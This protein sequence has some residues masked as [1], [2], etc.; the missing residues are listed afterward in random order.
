MSGSVFSGNYEKGTGIAAGL[1]YKKSSKRK[2]SV[3]MSGLYISSNVT[4]LGSQINLQRNMGQLTEII[5]RLSTG[6]KINSGKDDPSGLIA[7]ELLKSDITA[8]KQAI[9]NTTKA[10]SVVAIADSA[11]GQISSLL[12]DIRGLVNASA[13]TGGMTADQIAANQ[14]QVDASID[15]IDRIAKTTNYQGQLL[16]D[17]SFAFTTKGVDRNLI[18]D[19]NINAANFGMF[20]SVDLTIDILKDAAEAKLTYAYG[21]LAEASVIEIGG[22]LGKNIFKFD[23]GATV[24]SMARAINALSDSTG[25]V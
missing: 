5:T 18:S 10:N 19:L 2:D 1:L 20:P 14:L 17:G 11:L 3:T 6:L 23:A 24:D 4:A 16:L 8:T 22:N 9:Q 21:A 13:N 7:S 15:S 12:N 25:V